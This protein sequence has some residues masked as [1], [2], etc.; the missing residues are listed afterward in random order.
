MPARSRLELF[1]FPADTSMR[2]LT[3]CRKSQITF[4]HA[5]PVL[6][7]IAQARTLHR[8]RRQNK[9]ND[10]EW[11]HR[12]QQPMHFE[13]PRSLRSYLQPD[14]FS[15]GGFDGVGVLCS[16]FT[17]TL[18]FMPSRCIADTADGVPSYAGLMTRERFLY[19]SKIVK[20]DIAKSCNHP[21]VYEISMLFHQRRSLESKEV[22]LTWQGLR[23]LGWVSE[24][25][26]QTPPIAEYP[27]SGSTIL[28]NGG[29]S[30]GNVRLWSFHDS[31][32]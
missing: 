32:I 10:V 8:L 1:A 3:N 28:A 2:I 9:V 22:A 30:M 17:N 26:G 13:G 7:Q 4:G 11:K 14:W 23:D 20:E 19:R 18:P 31:Y 21:L 6:A 25:I 24:A 15:S 16:N 27:G 12:V 29:S 5:L